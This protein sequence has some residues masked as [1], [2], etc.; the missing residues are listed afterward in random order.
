MI[1]EGAILDVIAGPGSSFEQSF[2]EAQKIIASMKGYLSHELKRCIEKRTR[3][4]LLVT[5]ETVGD[6][7]EG[8][9]SAGE[10]QQWKRLVPHYYHPCP[11]VEHY[12][13]LFGQDTD[14]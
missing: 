13:S 12:E 7:T 6:H 1:L 11:E 9:R 4:R 14:C 5:W 3:Y 2:H 10:Y 8:F